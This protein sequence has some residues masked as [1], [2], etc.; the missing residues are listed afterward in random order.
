[1]LELLC[2]VYLR[3][4]SVR[5]PGQLERN[6]RE[7]GA[8]VMKSRRIVPASLKWMTTE[9]ITNVPSFVNKV[10]LVSLGEDML[11]LDCATEV[12]TLLMVAAVAMAR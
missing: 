3:I 1:M 6:A 10:L 8:C 5:M 7:S 4:V 2:S 11:E 9:R 12:L